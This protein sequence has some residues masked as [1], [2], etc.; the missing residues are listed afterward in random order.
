MKSDSYLIISGDFRVVHCDH[1]EQLINETVAKSIKFA[2]LDGISLKDRVLL[3]KGK[4]IPYEISSIKT[5]LNFEEE[6]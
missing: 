6:I 1:D 5:Y 2:G 4:V 3:V